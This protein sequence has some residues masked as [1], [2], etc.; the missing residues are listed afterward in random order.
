MTHVLEDEMLSYLVIDTTKQTGRRLGRVNSR[1]LEFGIALEHRTELL[2]ELKKEPRKGKTPV[3]WLGDGVKVNELVNFFDSRLSL[4]S[5]PQL[6][7]IES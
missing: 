7:Q 3:I 1:H 6:A 2:A 4:L 5:G